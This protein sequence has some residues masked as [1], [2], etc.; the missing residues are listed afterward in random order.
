ML[1]RNNEMMKSHL[2]EVGKSQQKGTRMKAHY[3]SPSSQN[4]FINECGQLV[5]DTVL[6][7]EPAQQGGRS[8]LEE[9]GISLHR[10]S[11]T[12]W[13]ARI[14]AIRPLIQTPREIM[15]ALQRAM[16]ELDLTGEMLAQ[17][18]SLKKWLKSFETVLLL[19]IW[20][21]ILQCVNDVSRLLQSQSISIEKT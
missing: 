2:E 9:I 15:K 20:V 19:T 5:M 16:D 18:R 8:F 17:A 6:S 3:L 1:S 12:R 21:K 7:P 11:T 13:S 14:D 10:F 4:K